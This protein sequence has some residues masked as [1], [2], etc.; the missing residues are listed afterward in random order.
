MPTDIQTFIT[1]LN[2]VA[3]SW[4]PPETHIQE[5]SAELFVSN[6]TENEL[7]EELYTRAERVQNKIDEIMGNGYMFVMS[8][9]FFIN[10]FFALT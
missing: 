9:Y 10:Q 6:D 7:I 4:D 1:E 8:K 3:F 2:T 5:L